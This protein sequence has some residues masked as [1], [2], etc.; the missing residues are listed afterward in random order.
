MAN[1][2][3][4]NVDLLND[5]AK[6]TWGKISTKLSSKVDTTT[7]V[8]GKPLSGNITINAT[9]VQAIP[10]S[11]K[12]A[13]NGV[14]GLGE[15]GKVP[16]SQLPSYVDDVV[17]GYL[18]TDGAFYKEAEHTT[19]ITAES[20]K[21]YVDIAT[22]KTYRW[23]GSAYVGIGSDLA[24]GETASTAY[25]GNKGKANADEIAKIKNGSTVVPKATDA[26]TVSGHTVATNVPENAKFT[27]TVYTPEYAT[28]SDID[29]IITAVFG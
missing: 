13:A 6:K 24:L 27:D 23:S 22:N 25:A 3:I 28:T 19:K 8:N 21:I 10:A 2:K 26:A 14:A 18:H 5:F 7:T 4:I 29:E 9:D 15:D 20:D 11:Q 16:A 12:G 1:N 17:E